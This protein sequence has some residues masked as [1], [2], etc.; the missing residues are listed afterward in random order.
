MLV[1][2]RFTHLKKMQK[3]FHSNK[4]E[5]ATS[6]FLI[7]RFDLTFWFL[8]PM[9][10]FST[11]SISKGRRLGR[12]TLQSTGVV[13]SISQL[14]LGRQLPTKFH[15]F[16]RVHLNPNGPLSLRVFDSAF[17][18]IFFKFNFFMGCLFNTQGRWRGGGGIPPLTPPLHATEKLKCARG[19]PLLPLNSTFTLWLSAII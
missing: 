14:S 2:H 8:P 10:I 9:N 18:Q 5:P 4:A 7:V 15:A 17:K 13:N 1:S 16:H 19:N 3:M 6:S 12:P 11:M